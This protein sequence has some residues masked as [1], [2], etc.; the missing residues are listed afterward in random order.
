MLEQLVVNGCSYAKSYATGGGHVDL[1]KR[2]DLIPYDLSIT[3]SANTRIIR[4]TLKHSYETTKNKKAFA[5]KAYDGFN[6]VVHFW[7]F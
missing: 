5:N 2:F 4:S 6:T 3:G 7:I 1:A